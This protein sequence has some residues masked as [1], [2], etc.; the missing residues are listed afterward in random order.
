MQNNPMQR[1]IRRF[2]TSLED[3]SMIK[4][5]LSNK[6]E[7]SAELNS[8]IIS[9]V[10]VKKGLQ[11]KFIFRYK[12]RDITKVIDFEEATHSIE[13]ALEVDFMNADLYTTHENMKLLI[14]PTGKV[15]IK[16][17]F[18]QAPIQQ[19][20]LSHNREKNRVIPIQNNVYLQELGVVNAHGELKKEMTDKYLQIN[21]YIELLEPEIRELTLPDGFHITD[22]GSGK[23][24]LT[25]ALYDYLTNILGQSPM[26]TGIEYREDMVNLCNSIAQ[27]ADFKNLNFIQGTIQD[28]E[29]TPDILIALH[30]CDTATDDAIYKGI[31]SNAS[32]IVCAPCCQ[33]QV[34]R[35]FKPSELFSGILKHGILQERQAEII[36]DGIRAMILEAWGYKT[37]VM[38]F[39]STEHTPKNLLIIAR[40]TR[41]TN[42]PDNQVLEAIKNIR[43]AFGIKGHYLEGLMSRHM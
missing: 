11:T 39:I 40:K 38:E 25:F 18:I 22:M 17:N 29:V 19:I 1:F 31:K 36:T 41:K 15:K 42:N 35:E 43:D 23:G 21:R 16:T 7:K 13:R 34:R 8:I 9:L 32:L 6:R 30:A 37:K 14:G 3:K 28:T 20:T 10:Q 24:Y 2:I 5:T 27:M 12:T 33:K 4:L 26:M